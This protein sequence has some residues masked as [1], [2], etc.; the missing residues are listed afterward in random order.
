MKGCGFLSCQ[1]HTPHVTYVPASMSELPHGA[2]L[3][4]FFHSHH[5]N[6]PAMYGG[7]IEGHLVASQCSRHAMR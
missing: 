1:A 6:S 2:G 3:S 4:A 7:K 5:Q